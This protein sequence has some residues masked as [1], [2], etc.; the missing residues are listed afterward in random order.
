[1]VSSAEEAESAA[2]NIGY[3]VVA[4]IVSPDI[5]HKTETGGVLLNLNDAAAVRGAY[6][7]ITERARQGTA[8]VRGVLIS[9]MAPPGTEVIVGL[10]QDPQFGP[11][12]MF[13]LG[14]VFV[15]VYQDVSFRLVPLAERD[16]AAMIQD[17]KA[18][19]MLQGVR[20]KRPAD[21]QALT[22]LLLKISKIA[23]ENVEIA[24]M[25]LNPII[26]YEKGLSVVDVRVLLHQKTPTA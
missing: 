7:Q 11:M 5:L 18:F 12:V 9:R 25:D 14:G 20:G 1:M 21:L 26:V 10:T 15:E 24:E 23:E 6:H 2:A 16:A 4:K 3:P 8:A 19:P 22:D 13:G 17:V